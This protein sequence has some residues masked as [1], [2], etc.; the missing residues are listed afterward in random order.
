MVVAEVRMTMVMMVMM[1]AAQA[2]L[3]FDTSLSVAAGYLWMKP[4]T[5]IRPLT[6]IFKFFFRNRPGTIQHGSLVLNAT[7]KCYMF[8]SQ[9]RHDN[10][11]T[12]C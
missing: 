3:L 7:C 11:I 5:A 8:K 4:Y 9:N 2:A 12:F 6:C 10:I 1:D